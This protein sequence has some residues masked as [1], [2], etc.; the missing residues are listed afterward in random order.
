MW[1]SF[2][3]WYL[4]VSVFAAGC[5]PRLTSFMREESDFVRR[6]WIVALGLLWPLWFPIIATIAVVSLPRIRREIRTEYR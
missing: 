2:V 6:A 4:L 1:W 5:Q 3:V